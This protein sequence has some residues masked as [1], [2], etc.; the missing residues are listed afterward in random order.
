M[1]RT[2][3]LLVDEGLKQ[4]CGR[5]KKPRSLWLDKKKWVAQNMQEGIVSGR[6]VSLHGKAT[7]ASGGVAGTLGTGGRGRATPKGLLE[8]VSST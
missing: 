8:N 5:W 7:D 4:I 3:K 1:K 6:R 2:E